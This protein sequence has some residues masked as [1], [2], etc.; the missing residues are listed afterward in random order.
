[1][2]NLWSS[3]VQVLGACVLLFTFGWN[4]YYG[5]HFYKLWLIVA[6]LNTQCWVLHVQEILDFSKRKWL[7]TDSNHWKSLWLPLQHCHIVHTTTSLYFLILSLRWKILFNNNFA[8]RQTV[9][10]LHSHTTILHLV[11]CIIVT[12]STAILPENV[13]LV[14]DDPNNKNN[15]FSTT[16]DHKN[17]RGYHH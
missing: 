7:W 3:A 17:N 2:L 13:V 16:V 6:S 9:F 5:K 10:S 12:S 1:M 15:S 4:K 11:L 14:E 8:C